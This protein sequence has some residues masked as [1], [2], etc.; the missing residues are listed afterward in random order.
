VTGPP[1]LSSDSYSSI[2]DVRAFLRPGSLSDS[3]PSYDTSASS[4][5]G[6]PVRDAAFSVVVAERDIPAKSAVGFLHS[7]T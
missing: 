1:P 7:G 4:A 6:V 5:E 3:C 2:F